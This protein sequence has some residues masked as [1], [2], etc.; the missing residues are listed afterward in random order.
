MGLLYDF[1]EVFM[2]VVYAMV[3]MCGIIFSSCSESD[4]KIDPGIDLK[5]YDSTLDRS[6]ELD[7]KEKEL[8][9]LEAEL[10]QK[11]EELSQ[12]QIAEAR[13][14]EYIPPKNHKSGNSTKYVPGDYPQAS[15]QYLNANE[16]RYLSKQDLLL[17]RN[18]I[19][20]RH[21]Y[22]FKRAD[23]HNHFITKPWYNGLYKDVSHFLS[24]IEKANIKM[25]KGF[26][27]L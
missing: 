10:K 26:E 16:L 23:L 1:F 21:G 25:I 20:A 6:E 7:Q 2:R 15:T 9:Q 11:S 18:E 12:G 22:I 27:D 17:M 14:D 13:P 4:K 5:K 19:F 8:Q 24:P 3:I